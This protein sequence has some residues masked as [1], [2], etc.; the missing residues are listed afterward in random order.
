[1][2]EFMDSIGDDL[3]F[4]ETRRYDCPSCGS[5]QTLSVKNDSGV[6]RYLCFKASCGLKGVGKSYIPP[7]AVWER[8]NKAKEA[9]G[10]FV[11]P[12][13]FI[14]GIANTECMDMLKRFNCLQVYK[15][16]GFQC[17]YDPRQNRF[18]FFVQD[19][20]HNTV[21]AVGRRV[22]KYGV[23][24]LNYV[25]SAPHPF[26]C[27]NGDELVLVEDCFSAA[28]VTRQKRYT[29]MALLGTNLKTEYIPFIKD[30]RKVY[31]ALD[32]DAR[33]KGLKIKETLQYY[34]KD[35]TVVFMKQDIKNIDNYTEVL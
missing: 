24:V 12:D 6:L 17:G 25:G 15:E 34:H 13:Y 5:R 18:V 11:I 16:G 21:G 30:Y 8:L 22:G 4:G 2:R 35:V 23:K 28:S 27:G 10:K 7:A 20:N 19:R 1:M 9:A 32:A 14:L 3:Q 33:T 29:G 26:I 31:I